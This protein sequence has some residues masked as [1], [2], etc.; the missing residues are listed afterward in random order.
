MT[1]KHEGRLNDICRHFRH[2]AEHSYC[3]EDEGQ[4]RKIQC[5]GFWGVHW[6]WSARSPGSILRSCDTAEQKKFP[7]TSCSKIYTPPDKVWRRGVA[8]RLATRR[9]DFLLMSL[10]F[11]PRTNSGAKDAARYRTTVQEITRWATKIIDEAP[12]RTLPILGLDLNYGLGIDSQRRLQPGRGI[13]RGS[14][15]EQKMYAA[16]GHFRPL[17]TYHGPQGGQTLIDFI[18]L[19]QSYAGSITTASVLFH[20][21]RTLQHATV[22]RPL[23]HDPALARFVYAPDMFRPPHPEQIRLDMDLLGVAMKTGYRKEIFM[24]KVEEGAKEEDTRDPPHSTMADSKWEDIVQI[25]QIAA[26]ECY[27]QGPRKEQIDG[28]KKLITARVT[29]LRLRAKIRNRL[30]LLGKGKEEV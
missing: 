1:V 16:S 13:R 26:G 15:S 24:K 4:A 3:R 29:T 6:G 12:H 8:I 27:A 25:L 10:Y 5:E 2:A 9:S 11:P 19:P 22:R 14:C 7:Q 23:D 20:S 30:V 28:Y 18:S 21:G 17:V